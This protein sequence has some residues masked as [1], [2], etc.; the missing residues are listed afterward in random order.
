MS[1]FNAYGGLLKGESKTYKVKPTLKLKS[2]PCTV[3]VRVN[4]VQQPCGL[5][6]HYTVGKNLFCREKHQEL[7]FATAKKSYSRSADDLSDRE[8]MLLRACVGNN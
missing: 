8:L 4:G 6:A 5:P 1:N 3:V 2:Q 7:A